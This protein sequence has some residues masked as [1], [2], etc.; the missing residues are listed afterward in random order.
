MAEV[1]HLRSPRVSVR[2]FY[3][4]A[5]FRAYREAKRDV[6]A[7]VARGIPIKV[8]WHR[9]PL[10]KR[11]IDAYANKTQLAGVHVDHPW[12]IQFAPDKKTVPWILYEHNVEEQVSALLFRREEGMFWHA[13]HAWETLSLYA[14]ERR[15]LPRFDRIVAICPEDKR[16]FMRLFGRHLPFIVLS[17]IAAPV[18]QVPLANT[19]NILFVGWMEWFPNADAAL[20]FIR[21]IFPIIRRSVPT[22]T[23]TLVGRLG[24]AA[25]AFESLPEGV[26]CIG[27]KKSIEPYLR[28]ARVFVQP[29]RMGA[30]ILFKVLTA[31]GAGIPMVSTPQGMRGFAMRHNREVLVAHSAAQFARQVVRLLQ[32]RSLAIG[33][34]ENALSHA[35][36]LYSRSRFSRAVRTIVS[37]FGE[38]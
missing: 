32:N 22:A 18:R 7:A 1:G 23:F 10:M 6:C 4:P 30:G 5:I 19:H 11:Y 12:S 36:S 16:L 2:C 37:P 31:M 38:A 9:N 25:P 29:F 34:R 15:A 21:E 33:I 24:S 28:R 13:F 17:P 14:Y 35:A 27:E 8:W 26:V 3:N 20:W